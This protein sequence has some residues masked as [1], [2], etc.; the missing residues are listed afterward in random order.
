MVGDQEVGPIGQD[1]EKKAHGDPVG[2]EG[3]G[4]SSRRGVAL[5]EGERG[6]G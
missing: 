1:G 5:Y 4:T 6:I 3:T 2:Q